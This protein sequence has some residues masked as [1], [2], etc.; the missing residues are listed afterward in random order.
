MYRSFLSKDQIPPKDQAVRIWAHRKV[1]R[2]Y[3]AQAQAKVDP[4]DRNLDQDD[5]NS[6]DKTTDD[7]G[8]ANNSGGKQPIAASHKA[9]G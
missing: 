7:S 6:D 4:S 8:D 9:T 1:V 5:S 3:Q 2:Q